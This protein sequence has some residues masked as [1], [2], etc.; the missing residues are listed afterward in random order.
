MGK[1][2]SNRG[3]PGKWIHL[4][5]LLPGEVNNDMRLKARQHRKKVNREDLEA[6]LQAYTDEIEE[7]RRVMAEEMDEI[8]EWYYELVERE[9]DIEWDY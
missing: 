2:N 9:D 8:A 5:D 6:G 1:R 4:G 7:M 3:Q